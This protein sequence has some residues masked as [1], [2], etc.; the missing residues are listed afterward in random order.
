MNIIMAT[1]TAFSKRHLE[2]A[3]VPLPNTTLMF[4]K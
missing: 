4:A 2:M 1:M 3:F